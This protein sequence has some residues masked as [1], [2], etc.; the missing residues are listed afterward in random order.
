[1]DKDWLLPSCDCFDQYRSIQPSEVRFHGEVQDTEC[2][3]WKRLVDLVET[4]ATDGRPEFSPFEEIPGEEWRQLVTLPATIAK[5]KAVRRFVLYRT[6]LV[7][8]PPEIGE[9]ENL[10]RFEPYTSHRLHWFPYEITRCKKLTRSVV[11]TRSLYGNP[12]H[13]PPFPSLQSARASTATLD[14]A[15]LLPAIWGVEAVATC[16]VCGRSL[17]SGRLHQAW[18]SAPVATDVLPLLV[19]ACSDRCVRELPPGAEGFVKTPH[20][21]GAAVQQPPPRH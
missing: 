5:L 21:G 6:W 2:D 11:S 18:L 10:E 4:A 1:M 15:R 17:T 13:R 9:M 7:R 3:G 19:N 16:S 14:L 8:I 20:G 12:K